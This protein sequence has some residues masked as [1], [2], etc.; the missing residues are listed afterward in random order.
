MRKIWYYKVVLLF[1]ICLFL[2]TFVFADG[3]GDKKEPT[4]QDVSVHDPS[5][6]KEGDTYYVFGTHIE[7][8][9]SKDLM[10][11]TSFANGYETPGNAIY[12]DLSENLAESFKWAGEDDADSKGG[13]AVWAPEIFWNDDYVN[14]DGTTGAYMIYYSAS[15]TYIRSAIGY[16]VSQDIEGP[17]EY[18]D[19]I[20]YSGFT[21]DEDYD[22]DSDVNK[23]WEN[24]NIKELIDEET[25]DAANDDWF[26]TDGSYNNMMYPNAIDANLFYDE[27][28]TLWMTYGSWSG[29]IFMLEIDPET[30]QANYPGE[31]D[32]TDDGRMIDRYFGTKIA[33]GYGESGEG[34]YAL[35][36]EET[37]YYYLYVT[38][39]Y[40]DASG[41]YN[42][43][44]FRA[45]QP[46]GPYV[47]AAGQQA[48]LPEDTKNETYGNKLISNY[49]F[50]QDLGEPGS[51]DGLGYVSAGHN[52]VYSDPDTG[53]QFLLFHTRFPNKGEIHEL[54]VH[55]MFLNKDDWPVVAPHRYA[56]ETLDTDVTTD[57]I[58]GTYKWINH[59]K[60][61]ASAL[62]I[63]QS[64][65]LHDDQTITG[66]A[67]GTWSQDGYFAKITIDDVTYNGV[68][69]EQWDTM[70]ESDVMTFTALS[71][72]GVSIWGSQIK[73]SDQSEEEIVKAVLED[74]TIENA[75]HVTRDLTLPTS[76]TSGTKI[77]WETSNDKIVTDTGEVI[78]PAVGE[79]PVEATLTATATNGQALATTEFDITVK[80]I[81][82]GQLV[83]HYP[84][85]NDLEDISGNFSNGEVVGSLIDEAEGHITFTEGQHGDA[86]VFDGESGIKLPDGLIQGDA[87][88]VS[89]WVKPEA[90]TEHTTTFFGARDEANWVSLVPMGPVDDQTM[91][92]SGESWYDGETGINMTANEWYHLAFTVDEGDLNVYVDGEN[93][94]TGSGFPDIFNT[95]DGQ[96]ALGVNYWDEPYEGLMDDLLIYEGALTED[97]I[98][99]YFEDGVIPGAESDTDPETE[100]EIDTSDLEDLLEEAESISNDDDQYTEGSFAAFEEALEKARTG[101]DDLQSEAERDELMTMLQEAMDGLEKKQPEA[102][103]GEG[104]SVGDDTTIDTDALEQLIAE[105]KDKVEQTETYTEASIQ[106]LEAAILDAESAFENIQTEDDLDQAI[107]QLQD[108]LDGLETV[109]SEE[110]NDS[111]APVVENDEEG[112]ELPKTA[113]PM[114]RMLLI[115]F[116]LLSLGGLFLLLKRRKA[117]K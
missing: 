58:V 54:R 80:P 111:E 24:T 98:V 35:Y 26:N 3:D 65:T 90:L 5:I 41:G 55:Q 91:V 6:I 115:G 99:T 27:V 82:G 34:P 18:V 76:G 109:D 14:E 44:Q 107:Q 83:A 105:A 88:T 11:W 77:T 103:N 46:E 25:V 96:F 73:R 112:K 117:T 36:D 78:R 28:G 42:M 104:E 66:D 31:D 37:G 16:A 30:G 71:D 69:V 72:D 110:N 4:F 61:N 114:F 17:Y 85:D 84:F 113:T 57:D 79:D 63:S 10:N 51:G 43:R 1:M 56:G 94:F 45:T 108:I 64:I 68:F 40:L 87:Y 74:I 60:D 29:S 32:T 62:N 52:S 23:Q 93:R 75:D 8:A 7:A 49:K 92:W 89:V 21:E 33:G 101:L 38:Y 53:E 22:Q 20:V 39:G 97:E 13:F 59:Q 2:P 70:T 50:E 95:T 12:G 48:V 116:V 19:T 9:K 67:E 81:E 86:V 102:G 47:D 100:P 106:Q 15:S